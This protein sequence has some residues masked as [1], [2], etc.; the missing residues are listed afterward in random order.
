M[1]K[2]GHRPVFSLALAVLFLLGLEY[3]LV[4]LNLVAAAQSRQENL[5]FFLGMQTI[6]LTH[7]SLLACIVKLFTRIKL[8]QLVER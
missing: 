5:H 4:D 2:T 8:G 1:K 6:K 7:Q 3:S